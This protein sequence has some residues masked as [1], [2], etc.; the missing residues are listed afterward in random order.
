[1]KDDFEAQKAENIH[2]LGQR[3]ELIDLSNQWMV[4]VSKLNYSY[5]FTWMG[6]P[7][8]QFPQDMIA[9]QEII[10]SC[11]PDLIVETGI[12]RGGSLIY[13]ASLLQLL[14]KG[15]RI[16]G[17]DVDIR[18]ANRAA[19]ESHPT[20]DRIT[21]IE[22]SSVDP[23]V[24]EKVRGLAA[25]AERVMVVLDSNHTH[26]HVLEE[27]HLYSPLV[28]KGSYLVVFDTV[29]E[30]M[31]GDFFP[32]R[33]WGKG[34][35]PRTAVHAFLERSGRFEIDH[36]IDAKLQITVARDGYLRCVSD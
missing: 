29:I 17:I 30:D 21:M 14:G 8:I 27:L 33:P 25:E 18:P 26:D 5:H 9:M 6:I 3:R 12:A 31:P 1:M 2:K 23:I 4:E 36:S 24:L 34:N 22:G 19:I 16:L 15:G 7:I 28:T 20:F 13:Y 35:N 11:K 32:D 10:W